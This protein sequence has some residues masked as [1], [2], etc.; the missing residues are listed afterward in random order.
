MALVAG[1]EEKKKKGPSTLVQLLALLVLTAIA[2]GIGW[3][4]GDYLQAMQAPASDT[5]KAEE[6]DGQDTDQ[7]EIAAMDSPR[8]VALEPIMTSLADPSDIWVRLELAVV[9]EDEPSSSRA[10]EIHQDL[11][12]YIRTLKLRQIDTPSGLQNLKTDLLERAR[13]RSEGQ[14][15]DILITTFLYE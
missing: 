13:I 15:S 14:I 10:R 1:E 6:E 12:A 9:F 11:F 5:A 8:V 3:Y 2:G 7:A 4:A